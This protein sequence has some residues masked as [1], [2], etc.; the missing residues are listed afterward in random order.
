MKKSESII[1]LS[2]ALS[3]FQGEVTNPKNTSTN[4]FFSSKYAPLEEVLN[5]IRPVLATNGLS[6]TQIPTT[7]GDKVGVVTILM[8]SSGEYIE[9][10]PLLLKTDKN[11]AQGAGSAITYARRYAISAILGVAS[12]EDD[13][14]N[15][16][17]P[18]KDNKKTN[19]FQ[20]KKQT[21]TQNTKTQKTNKDS[22]LTKEQLDSLYKLAETKEVS[23]GNVKTEAYNTYGKT[24]E[25]LG[26]EEYNKLYSKYKNM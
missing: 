6:I 17:E 4:P 20:S 15:N 22:K 2:K 18:S 12:E 14:G 24:P 11:T 21:S 9:T 19:K 16:A 25:L 8:H 26:V 3:K 10:E 23:I 7:E 5:T 13:D 1:E